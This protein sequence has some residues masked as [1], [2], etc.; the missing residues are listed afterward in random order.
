MVGYFIGFGLNKV[1]PEKYSGWDGKLNAAENDIKSLS[2]IAQKANFIKFGM[3][4]GEK[5]TCSNLSDCLMKLTVQAQ[6]GDIVWIAYSGHG[7]QYRKGSRLLES[8]CLFDGLFPETEMRNLIASLPSGVRVLV[9]LD[10]CH[11]GGMDKSFISKNF[12]FENESDLS[13]YRVK[14]LPMDIS[15]LMPVEPLSKKSASL[16]INGGQ[17]VKWLT[18]CRKDEVALDGVKNGVFTSALIVAYRDSNEANYENMFRTISQL[19]EPIQH[20][21]LKNSS[22][23]FSDLERFLKVN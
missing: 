12:L 19:C 6:R 10:C 14:S 1:N 15:M 20:P 21:Q 2:E 11:A 5:A 9:T 16:P 7:A 4:T 18:A 17:L 22:S 23:L 3:L 8:Y 13:S